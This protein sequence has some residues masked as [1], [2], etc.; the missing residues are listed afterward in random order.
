MLTKTQFIAASIV[1]IFVGL[2]TGL[3]IKVTELDQHKPA[4]NLY[5]TVC[6]KDECHEYI[7]ESYD[8]VTD[9]E[10]CK[11]DGNELS[12]QNGVSWYCGKPSEYQS[13]YTSK[14]TKE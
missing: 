6:F 12:E 10:A 1:S 2:A 11:R 13:T 4:L 9:L 14:P 5:Y 7:A 8:S 3:A